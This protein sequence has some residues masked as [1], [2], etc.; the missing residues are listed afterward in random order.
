MAADVDVLVLTRHYAPEPTGSGPPMQQLAEWLAGAGRSV[1]VVT[2]RPSYPEP[3]V[4]AGY[5]RGERD[6][7]VENGVTVR[8][9]P[10]WGMGT[11]SLLRRALPEARFL[12]QL[13]G[14]TATGRLPR[15]RAVVTL[16]PSILTVAA[17]LAAARGGAR[18]VVIVH[19]IQSGL[20]AALGGRGV[21]LVM[22]ALRRVERWALARADHLV[23]LSPAM[24]EA[25]AALGVATPVT[26]LPPQIDCSAIRPMPSGDGPPTLMYSGNLGRKQGLDQV[27]DLAAVLRTRAPEVRLVIRGDGAMRARLADRIARERLGNVA[28]LPLVPADEIAAS[29]AQA[30]LHLVPQVADGGDFAVPSK[31]FAIMAA[32]RAFVATATP[33]SS[34]ARLA[35]ESGA[36]AITPPDDA[37]AFAGLVLAL[38][39]DPARREAMGAAGRRY[40]EATADTAV[41]TRRIE[42]LLGIRS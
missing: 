33:G 35:D 12:A 41:V 6:R 5:A 8:R 16:C 37:A 9:L 18:H 17:G 13:L 36:F 14:Q 25:I 10:T 19:D 30:D 29:L 28:L 11:A 23:V 24:A 38:L 27:L 22:A 31:A 26:I 20:G 1:A 34:I 2:S 40:A 7:A 42:A 39:A 4:L 3:R 15:P 21:R 32:G